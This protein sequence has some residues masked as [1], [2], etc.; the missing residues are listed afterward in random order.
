MANKVYLTITT[1]TGSYLETETNIVTVKTTEGYI[2]LQANGTE[3]MAAL[4]A[5]KMFVT[6]ENNNQKT[7][8]INQGIVHAKD[9]KI[10]IIVNNI[11]DKAL[12]EIKFKPSDNSNFSFIEE[13]KLKRSIAKK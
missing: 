11:S 12:E 9:D 6:S 2:G 7:Y 8:Y 4:V 5:S 3:F 10:D 13:T 1:P